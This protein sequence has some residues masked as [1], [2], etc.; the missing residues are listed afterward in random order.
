L[1]IK[2]NAESEEKPLIVERLFKSYE[3]ISGD[4]CTVKLKA[5]SKK[6]SKVNNMSIVQ[7][8]NLSELKNIF[9]DK[10][11]YVLLISTFVVLSQD[12]LMKGLKCLYS[13]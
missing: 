3:Y 1:I 7:I 9:I 5:S 4:K 2:M 11:L 10:Y 6:C 13:K 8:V 12:M